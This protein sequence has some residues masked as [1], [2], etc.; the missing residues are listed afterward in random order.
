MPTET[1]IIIAAITLIFVTFAATLAWADFYTRDFR[2]PN[3]QDFD[4]D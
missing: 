3:P 1:A 4:R 2:A